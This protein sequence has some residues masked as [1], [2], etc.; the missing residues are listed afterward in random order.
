L[1][2]GVQ[3]ADMKLAK[4]NKC[5]Y[6]RELKIQGQ[7]TEFAFRIWNGSFAQLGHD[8]R[9][10]LDADFEAVHALREP[11]K[12]VVSL[13]EAVLIFRVRVVIEPLVVEQNRQFPQGAVHFL[14]ARPESAVGGAGK[15]SY[16]RDWDAFPCRSRR[17]R[18]LFL[19][20]WR[21]AFAK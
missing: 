15:L 4:D 21:H 2:Q 6:A 13:I 1:R 19:G 8:D 17:E 12:V 14:D 3:F 11:L 9:V 5:L 20:F 10:A 16:G 18:R 7:M